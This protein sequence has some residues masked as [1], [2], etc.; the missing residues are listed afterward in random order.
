MDADPNPYRAPAAGPSPSVPMVPVFDR[1]RI[2]WAA[3]GWLA[4]IIAIFGLSWVARTG[5][6]GPTGSS[7]NRWM[8]FI[9][10]G[11]AVTFLCYNLVVLVLVLSG[12]F[13]KTALPV[14]IQDQFPTMDNDPRTP[15]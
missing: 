15:R 11:L 10:I 5:L 12:F 9:V 6:A 8:T 4:L 3:A 13:R 7:G 2:L 14:V 1:R